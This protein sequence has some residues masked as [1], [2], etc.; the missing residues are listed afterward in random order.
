MEHVV[1]ISIQAF[2]SFE[3]R[4]DVSAL[5]PGRSSVAIL[6]E[7]NEKGKYLK[8]SNDFF[9]SLLLLMYFGIIS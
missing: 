6:K 9:H 2:H 1:L 5:D 8:E 7:T 4:K 3:E